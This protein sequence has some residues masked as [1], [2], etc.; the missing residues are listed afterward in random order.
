LG[1]AYWNLTCNWTYSEVY[2][3]SYIIYMYLYI[4]TYICVYMYICICICNL[5]KTSFFNNKKVDV[6]VKYSRQGSKRSELNFWHAHYM[7][8]LIKKHRYSDTHVQIKYVK[9]IYKQEKIPCLKPV[10]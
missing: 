3:H 6:Y 10:V 5:K 2:T 8:R 4:Y 7:V 1:G 9:Y